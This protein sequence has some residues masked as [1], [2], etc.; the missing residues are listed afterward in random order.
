VNSKAE[1]IHE[2]TKNAFGKYAYSTWSTQFYYCKQSDMDICGKDWDDLS[3][4]LF[5]LHD[6]R[7]NIKRTSRMYAT[8]LI[9]YTE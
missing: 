2:M 3:V 6:I 7:L 9:K 5:H 1:E 4:C 8:L